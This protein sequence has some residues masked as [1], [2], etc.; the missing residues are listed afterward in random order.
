M[1]FVEHRKSYFTSQFHEFCQ[2]FVLDGIGLC[3]SKIIMQQVA[4]RRMQEYVVRQNM[5]RQ[6]M[7]Q[8]AQE[9]MKKI[10]Q[11]RTEAALRQS[12]EA[13]YNRALQQAQQ[14]T[15]ISN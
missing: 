12:V 15:L 7:Q 1:F 6:A 8:Y 10:V 13:R 11:Q 5:A 9:A 2:C 4:Q 14:G 3:C